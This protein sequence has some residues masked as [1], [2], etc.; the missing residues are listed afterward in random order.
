MSTIPI[1]S[2]LRTNSTIKDL[3]AYLYE[4][5]P[6]DTDLLF[7]LIKN[8]SSK[9]PMSLEE[10]VK[11]SKR[12]KTAV[13][14]SLQK[15]ASIG[16]C[17]KEIKTKSKGGYNHTYRIIDMESF[18]SETEKKVN[19]LEQNIHSLLKAFESHIRKTITTFYAR[20]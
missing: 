12:K 9:K 7:I 11:V 3:F 20:T 18:K 14:R 5:S 6:L 13:H 10:L 15:L 16:L 1:S 19:E 8:N 4:L 2:L 17:F